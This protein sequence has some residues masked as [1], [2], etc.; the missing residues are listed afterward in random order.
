VKVAKPMG[1]YF[2][3]GK[4]GLVIFLLQEFNLRKRVLGHFMW[5]TA[6]SHQTQIKLLEEISLQNWGR[7]LT[8]RIKL[9]PGTQTLSPFYLTAK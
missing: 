8:S 5:M 9:S 4:K 2:T 1:G 6:L 7:S 3:T